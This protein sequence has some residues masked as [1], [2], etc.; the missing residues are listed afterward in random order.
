VI[1]VTVA[2]EARAYPIQILT[3]HEIVNDQIARVPVAV[4][5]CPLCNTAI[6]F[7]RRLD[8]DVLSFGTTG[9]LRESDLVMYDRKTE[10]WWQ[11]FSG[12]ALVGTL[13]GKKLRQLPHASSRGKS[14]G[15]TIRP[16]SSSTERPGSFASTA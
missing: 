8:G 7:D 5:F 2:D 9:K 15:T 10:S 14:S 1:V 12:E 3:W 13:A 11:Q 16:G 6:V 4:T